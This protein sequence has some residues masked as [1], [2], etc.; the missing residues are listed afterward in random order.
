MPCHLCT[1]NKQM[2]ERT[3]FPVYICKR[4]WER[5]DTEK[6]DT[7]TAMGAMHSICSL[8]SQLEHSKPLPCTPVRMFYYA[9]AVD[10]SVCL[11]SLIPTVRSM[12]RPRGGAFGTNWR[13]QPARK[14]GQIAPR[15]RAH[16]L[17]T[18]HPEGNR[19]IQPVWRRKG[20]RRP[21]RLDPALGW[22]LLIQVWMA[23]AW[24]R[25]ATTR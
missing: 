25:M 22:V 15:A 10:T 1:T 20:T 16:H 5:A 11:P 4:E 12:V 7:R 18:L 21:S 6:T 14:Q 8:K 3:Y 2:C 13:R 23:G 9:C 17:G 19:V 24:I